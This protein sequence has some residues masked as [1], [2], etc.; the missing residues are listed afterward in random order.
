MSPPELPRNAPVANVVEP[1][2]KDRALIVGHHLDQV[3]AHDFLRRLRQRRHL[4][5]PLRGNPRLHFGLAAVAHAHRVRDVLD[6]FEQAQ[7]LKIVHDAGA[8]NEAVEPGIFSGGRAHV[9]V[10]GHHVDFGQVVALPDFEVVGI[11]RGGDLHH[12]RPEFAVHVGVRDHG[13]LAVH[14]GQHHGF[15]D[16]ALVT[17]VIRMHGHGRI[18]QHRFGPGGGHNKIARCHPQRLPRSDSEGATAFRAAR[19]GPLPG[20]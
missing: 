15:A 7:F 19:C 14:Q 18:A 4:A 20:R 1:V 16:K 17:L 13:N 9:R 8:R 2:Q 10:G 5:E 11:V 12:A 3:F 6:F